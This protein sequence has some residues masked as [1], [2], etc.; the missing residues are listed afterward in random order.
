MSIVNSDKW[1]TAFVLSNG[2]LHKKD[3][4]TSHGLIRGSN[5]FNIRAVIDSHSAGKDAGEVVDGIN[6]GIPVYDNLDDAIEKRGKPDYCI[7]GV[8]TKGGI[9]PDELLEVIKNFLV[10]GI[11]VVNGL[12]YYL[13]DQPE[14]VELANTHGAGLIDVRRPKAF[15]DLHFWSE[16]IYQVHCPIIAV[17]GMDCAMGKR[18]ATLLLQEAL[19]KAGLRT[20]V[21]YTGQTGWMQ[22]IKYGFILDSTLNDFVSGELSHAIIT[23]YKAEKPDLILLEGQSSL[24]NPSGPCGAEY[25]VSGNAKKVILIHQPSREHFDYKT[26][27]GRIPSVKNEMELINLYGSEVI[28]LMLN[29]EGLTD[30]ESQTY[31]ETYTRSLKI[32]VVLTM[33]DGLENFV[34]S[35]LNKINEN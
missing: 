3:S 27:W 26:T 29:T 24:R 6:R 9:L 30:T 28:G 11:S 1:G 7:I 34:Q 17:L 33:E 2:V 21:I 22:G 32:P 8:A 23:A 5:R 12:H 35:L 16:D 4:K 19:E 25:L 15:R 18:T 14:L 13:S 31:K 20:E 10:R